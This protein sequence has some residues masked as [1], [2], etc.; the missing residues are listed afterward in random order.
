[1]VPLGPL[2]CQRHEVDELIEAEAPVMVPAQRVADERKAIVKLIKDFSALSPT[3][4]RAL[5]VTNLS[6]TKRDARWAGSSVHADK[7]S[8]MPSSSPSTR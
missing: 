1:M 4:G 6:A 5:P 3:H 8:L 7:G 2:I